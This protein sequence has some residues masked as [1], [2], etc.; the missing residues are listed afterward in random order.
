MKNIKKITIEEI[1]KTN[2]DVIVNLLRSR[3]NNGN[4]TAVYY[5]NGE[6][7]YKERSGTSTNY[8]PHLKFPENWKTTEIYKM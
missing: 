3:D 5:R 8:N 2:G 4:M 1:E 7:V 6:E